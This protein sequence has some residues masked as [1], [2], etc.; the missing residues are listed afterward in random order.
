ML[1]RLAFHRAQPVVLSKAPALSVGVAAVV[2]RNLSSKASYKIRY[3]I[4]IFYAAQL[5]C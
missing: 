1:T 4:H 2:A 5:S 3:M